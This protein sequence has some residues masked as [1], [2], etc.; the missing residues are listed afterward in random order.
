MAQL[1]QE[2]DQIK[3]LIHYRDL[4][5]RPS[6]NERKEEDKSTL[7]LIRQWD[8]IVANGEGTLFRKITDKQGDSVHQLLLPS[9]L[10]NDVLQA[11]HDNAGHQAL[12]RTEHLIRSRCYWPTMA[13]DIDNYIKK[14]YRCNQAKMPYH[15]LKT[16]LGRLVA[17]KPLECVAV[18]F[19]VLEPSSDGRENVWIITDVFTKYTVASL[20]KIRKLQLWQKHYAKNGS[21]G[22]AFLFVFKAT[23]VVT[24]NQT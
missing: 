9:C 1:Q 5:R 6:F 16:P 22:M 11:L 2:D 14:C 21:S 13:K 15:Q 17:S 18:D 3:R 19:T 8:R 12:E 20:V 23:K 24:L 7:T 10:K 4:N